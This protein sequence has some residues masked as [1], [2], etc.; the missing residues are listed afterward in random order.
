MVPLMQSHDIR[1]RYLDFFVEKGHQLYPSSSLIPYNDP[2]VLLTTA[3]MQQFITYFTGQE[4]PPHPRATSA[5]KC[6]RTVDLE[7]VGDSTHLTFFEMLGNFSFGDYFKKEAIEWAWEFLTQELKLSPE[8][9]WITIFEGNEDAPEDLEAKEQWM[10]V[11]VPEERIFGLP[12]SEN[13]WGPPGDT[14][15]CGPCSEVYYD[16]G[17]ELGK[18]DP[19]IDPK[20]GPGGDEGDPR[21]VEIWNLVFNQY[22]QLKD[23]TLKPLSKPG[24]DTGMGLERTTAVA[25]NVRSV[26]E[27][28]LYA[29]IFEHIREETGAALDSSEEMDRAL[30]ILADHARAMAF[31]IAD[32]VRPGNQGREYVLRRIIR[33]AALQTYLWLPKLSPQA[34]SPM[35]VVRLATEA[36]DHMKTH[37]PELEE[38]YEE[39]ERVVQDEADRFFKIYDSGMRLLEAEIRRLPGGNFPGEVA[40]MLHDTYGFPVEVTREVLAEKGISLD[41]AG[42]EEAMRLQRERARDALRGHERLV[43]AFRDQDIKSR[44]VGYEREQV[45]TR[46]LAVEE[47]AGGQLNVVLAENP[48]YATGGGQVADEGWISSERGQV[49]VFDVVPAGDY[50]VL[51]T[52]GERGTVEAGD[53]VTASINRVR[54]QQVEANHTATHILHWALRA[55]LGKDVVQAGSYVGPDRLRF[56]YRHTNRVSETDLWRIQEQ[57]LLKITENQPVRYYTTTLEEARNLGAMMLFGEKYGDL[58]RVVEIDGFSRELCGG[59]HVRS[60]AEVGAFKIVSNKKHGADLYRIEV[61]TGREALYY[62]IGAAEKAEKIADA[63][64]TGVEE[65]PEAVEGLQKEVGEAREAAREQALRKG[66]EEV[67]SLVESADQMNGMKVVTG[68]VA[69]ADIKGLRQI[70]D[71]IKNRLQGPSAVV[72]AAA[73]GDKAVLVANLHPEVSQKIQAGEIVKEISGIL[74]GGGGGG[75]TMAQ[76]GGGEVDAIPQALLKARDILGQRLADS[77]KG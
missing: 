72:L 26:Y 17:E 23:G 29:P 12:K 65:L 7:E 36:A 8:R 51:R 44:F 43:A 77:A 69:A 5:Q 57:C 39:I 10:R 1:K 64:R 56:D 46:V 38:S 76:A 15:P 55:V 2:T 68:Q 3:G 35:F 62:L 49:D 59:T 27:T 73:L 52:R 75:P 54:R 11:G 25:Q 24:I 45:E 31:L 18:G 67:G 28:D 21:F 60:T 74:G 4:R 30:Y 22:E 14:G 41:E 34:T 16:Y 63:L 20:Y 70:S 66:L 6:F 61:L 37:Y 19:A 71:D 33:R 13:W 40:F 53:R 50:Q 42:F 47:A 58:V 32:G 9:L 48:F